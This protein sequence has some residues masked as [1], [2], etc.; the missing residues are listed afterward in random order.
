MND[1][2]NTIE[3]K[4]NFTIKIMGNTFTLTRESVEKLYDELGKILK[5]NEKLSKDSLDDLIKIFEKG[6]NV[7]DKYPN[8][9]PQYSKTYP[10]T[11]P[12]YPEIVYYKL[13]E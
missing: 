9:I 11:Y 7:D 12:I 5:K 13:S 2:S 1:E 10:K 6:K 3:I 8:K 4:E